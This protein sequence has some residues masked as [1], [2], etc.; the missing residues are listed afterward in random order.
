MIDGTLEYLMSSLP[1]LTFQNTEE[2]RGRI[3]GLLQKYAGI[4][5]EEISPAEVL[6]I[7][8][9][10]FLPPPAFQ[11][12]QKINLNSIHGLDFRQ[13][14]IT[15]LS[16]FSIFTFDLKN[17]IKQLQT[18][19]KGSEKKTTQSILEKLIAQGTPLEKE[20]RII[21]YQWDKLEDL[22]FGHFADLEALVIYKIKLLLLL[23][24]WSFNVDKGIRIF[25]R[26]TTIN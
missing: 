17:E 26:M 19:E 11:L 20:V 21:R 14:K 12:F 23:R 25:T 5:D 2:A 7:E 15:V 18:R 6:D 4:A 24:W 22:S 9:H 10:K 8:A 3:L 13:C 1:N 16:A